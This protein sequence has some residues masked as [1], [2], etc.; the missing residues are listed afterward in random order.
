MLKIFINNVGEEENLDNNV[1]DITKLSLAIF[2]SGTMYDCDHENIQEHYDCVISAYEGGAINFI[3]NM[4][5]IFD[6]LNK[7]GP[8]YIR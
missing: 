3:N 6:M 8:K 4:F 2:I 1:Y 5:Q 7:I